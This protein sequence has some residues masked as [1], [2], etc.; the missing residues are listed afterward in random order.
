[1]ILVIQTQTR[2]YVSLRFFPLTLFDCCSPFRSMSHFILFTNHVYGAGREQFIYSIGLI[3]HSRSVVCS[4]SVQ[5][6]QQSSNIQ[7]GKHNLSSLMTFFAIH[8]YTGSYPIFNAAVS[9]QCCC[10]FVLLSLL[11]VCTHKSHT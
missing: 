10:V 2:Q 9:C 6:A 1:M 5:F 3:A 11:T 4:T 7:Y 8:V